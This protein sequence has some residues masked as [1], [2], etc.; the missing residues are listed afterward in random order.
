MVKCGGVSYPTK[1]QIFHRYISPLVCLI[2]TSR[3][4]YVA[5][6][7]GQVLGKFDIINTPNQ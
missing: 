6:A 2:H 7:L 1:A 3:L 5:G 4:F